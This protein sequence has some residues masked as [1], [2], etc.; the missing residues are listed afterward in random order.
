MRYLG[1]EVMPILS[2]V[3][4]GSNWSVSICGQNQPTPD[5]ANVLR[6]PRIKIK[7][8]VNDID[9]EVLSSAIFLLLNNAGPYTG[10]YTRVVYACATGGC[11]IAHSNLRN[12]MPE[13]VSGQNCLLGDTPS[14]IA[15]QIKRALDDVGLRRRIGAAAR[16]TYETQYAPRQVASKLV[17]MITH[18]LHNQPGSIS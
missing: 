15:D 6:H 10:G 13:L 1:A 3:A 17:R 4:V 14:G 12:S 8:F 9:E 5:V 16:E 2:K 11:L 18:N 7:G